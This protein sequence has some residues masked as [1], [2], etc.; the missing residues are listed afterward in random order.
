M[1]FRIRDMRPKKCVCGREFRGG[2]ALAT[3]RKHC[4]VM[5]A[6]QKARI[7]AKMRASERTVEAREAAHEL[8]EWIGVHATALD[9][10]ARAEKALASARSGLA[11]AEG[12]L[13]NARET[14]A[15][16]GLTGADAETVIAI[17]AWIFAP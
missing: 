1:G 9:D 16:H 14:A 10:V 15:R 8:V 12:C 17:R 11:V 13:A 6:A 7:D 4:D 3:H 5:K 2:A